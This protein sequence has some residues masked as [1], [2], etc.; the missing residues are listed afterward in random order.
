MQEGARTSLRSDE[1][2]KYLLHS[3][4]DFQFYEVIETFVMTKRVSDNGPINSK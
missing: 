2:V 1:F 3:I 4:K